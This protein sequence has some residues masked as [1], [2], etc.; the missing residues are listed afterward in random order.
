MIKNKIMKLT[1]RQ[2]AQLNDQEAW[3]YAVEHSHP[4]CYE[5]PNFLSC[6]PAD[7][8]ECEHILNMTENNSY[9]S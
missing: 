7:W 8:Q 9:Y 5:C 6:R 1:Y 2:I 3:K 4:L